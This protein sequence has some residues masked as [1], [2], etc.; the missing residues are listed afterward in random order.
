MLGPSDKAPPQVGALALKQELAYTLPTSKAQ[1]RL[2]IYK[3]I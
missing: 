1:R 3:H 2:A